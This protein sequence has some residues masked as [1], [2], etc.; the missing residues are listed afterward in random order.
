MYNADQE[1]N[2]TEEDCGRGCQEGRLRIKPDPKKT[3]SRPGTRRVVSVPSVSRTTATS[4]DD[5]ERGHQCG[6]C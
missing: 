4:F 3:G 1:E 2:F 6:S 5:S